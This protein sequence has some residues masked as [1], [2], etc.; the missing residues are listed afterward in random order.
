[1]ILE[2]C[3]DGLWTLCLG[4]PQSHGHGSWLVCEVTLGSKAKCRRNLR[5]RCVKVLVGNLYG[6]DAVEWLCSFFLFFLLFLKEHYGGG[7]TRRP[8]NPTSI[9]WLPFASTTLFCFSHEPSSGLLVLPNAPNPMMNQI[10]H[11][12]SQ[13]S[14]SFEFNG[15]FQRLILNYI[16]TCSIEMSSSHWYDKWCKVVV[17][18]REYEFIS[19]MSFKIYIYNEF[20]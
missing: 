11:V 5:K 13:Y 1:M 12:N 14:R 3:W 8:D 6:I 2:V 10:A 4:L 19:N 9:Q 20:E 7:V 15:W 17:L 16:Q 18:L